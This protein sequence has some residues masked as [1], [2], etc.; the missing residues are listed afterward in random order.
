MNKIANK[1]YF[2]D[3]LK[4]LT[5]GLVTHWQKNLAVSSNI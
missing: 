3:N 2:Q 1:E 5:I 4:I